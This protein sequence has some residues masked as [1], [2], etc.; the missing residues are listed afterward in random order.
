MSRFDIPFHRSPPS[1]VCCW[2]TRIYLPF[3]RATTTVLSSA[4]SS[5]FGHPKLRHFPV[6]PR[7]LTLFPFPFVFYFVLNF[8]QEISPTPVTVAALIQFRAAEMGM[9][10][11]PR[12]PLQTSN[13]PPVSENASSA[14]ESPARG[15]EMRSFLQAKLRHPLVHTWE[16]W[17]EKPASAGHVA[18][19]TS[20]TGGPNF[21][22]A[23]QSEE[24][25]APRLTN[26]ISIS[27]IRGFWSLYNNFD[28]SS[29]PQRSS[30]HLFHS[31]V[32][33]LW[34]DPR[35]L[36]GGAWTFRVPKAAAPDFW[37][38]I[39][40]LAIGES[41]QE[42]ITTNRTTFKDDI[43]G[44]SFR[45]RYA[46]V[47]I[48]I[49]NRDGDH[50]EGI[51][52]IAETVVNSMPEHLRPKDGSYYYKK[53]S[54]HEGFDANAAK[55]N[56]ELKR[57]PPVEEERPRIRHDRMKSKE[58][59]DE[60]MQSIAKIIHESHIAETQVAGEGAVSS[61]TLSTDG[62]LQAKPEVNGAIA[63]NSIP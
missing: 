41:L 27:D 34:E 42:A 5:T 28:F 6:R 12:L 3:L 50:Q 13:L 2:S 20:N 14:V 46:S 30:V 21:N 29:L 18:S 62:E 7:R 23:P 43:C 15:K 51:Q 36:R 32:K 40:C 17:H 60:E 45:P 22:A 33:P 11:R 31:T 58:Q 25:F 54:D 8:T 4:K 24:Q 35:N 44:V 49:W 9:E 39:C 52:R 37:R 10:G 53:H 26:L 1:R 63:L 48:T 61:Q 38:E 16:F 57:K 19:P 55:K 47:L 59:M 56:E